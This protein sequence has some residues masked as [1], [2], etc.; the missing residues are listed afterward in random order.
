MRRAIVNVA[1]TTRFQRGQV[2]LLQSLGRHDPKSTH[3]VWVNAASHWPLHEH[4]PYAFK[5]FSLMEASA[6][7]DLLLWCDSSIVAQA[8]LEPLWK[9]I[10]RDGYWFAQVGPPCYP[11][12]TNY[13]WTAREAYGHLF[14]EMELKKAQELNRT[15]PQVYGTA[16]GLNVKSMIG[17]MFLEEFYRL[18]NTTAFC[19]SWENHRHDQTAASVL[20]WRL[21]MKLTVPPDIL[22]ENWIPHEGCILLIDRGY[23]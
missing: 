20:A 21:G 2:R 23:H 1:T 16:F 22:S 10:E 12:W 13:E 5:A 7:F 11:A 4:T 14:P 18:A 6:Q 8:S 15:F 17:K 3:L 9:R 19:G